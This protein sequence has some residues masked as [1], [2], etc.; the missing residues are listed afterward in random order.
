MTPMTSSFHIKSY[1]GVPLIRQ[2]EVIGV[3]ALD[4]T[5]RVTPFEPWQQDLGMAI[6]NQ[7][8]LALENQ[9]LY[10]LVQ[11]RLQ[12]ATVLLTVSQ[13]LSEPEGAGEALRRVAAE[14]GRT[15][16]ADMVGIYTL[17]SDKN[18]LLPSAGWHVPKPPLEN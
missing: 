17:S 18:S 5:D 8:A 9:R 3:M 4:Y 10:D 11:E 12:E 16:G 13:A 6:G 14:V 15:L 2:E 7:V 1:M